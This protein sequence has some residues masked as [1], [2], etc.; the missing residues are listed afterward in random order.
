[1]KSILETKTGR[2]IIKNLDEKGVSYAGKISFDIKTTY[3]HVDKIIELLKEWKLVK[4]RKSG[5]I[6]FLELTEEGK[7]KAKLLRELE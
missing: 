3:S 5:R 6:I 4:A 7:K 2:D 1:M